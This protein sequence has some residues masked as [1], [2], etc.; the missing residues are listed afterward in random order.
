M[1]AELVTIL[2]LSAFL[3]LVGCGT[4]VGRVY[5]RLIGV[6]RLAIGYRIAMVFPRDRL[7]SAILGSFADK[8]RAAFDSV[9][10]TGFPC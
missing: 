9:K 10:R 1:S 3:F 6:E 8:L 5:G 2:G 4:C 7:R